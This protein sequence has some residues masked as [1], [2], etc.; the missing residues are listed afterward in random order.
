MWHQLSIDIPL[1]LPDTPLPSLSGAVLQTIV[2]N[3]LRLDHNWK[4]REPNVK[5]VQ[6]TED[7]KNATIVQL[8]LLGNGHVLI[9]SRWPNY[10]ELCACRLLSQARVGLKSIPMIQFAAATHSGNCG[11]TIVFLCNDEYVFA[12][13]IS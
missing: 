4:K 6:V 9:L 12:Q 5:C 7:L 10:D 2:I 13:G 3:A 1:N 11:A 8:Q